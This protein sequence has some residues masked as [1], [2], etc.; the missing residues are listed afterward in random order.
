MNFYGNPMSSIFKIRSWLLLV[1]YQ[2]EFTCC[3]TSSFESSNVAYNI[4]CIS[5]FSSTLPKEHLVKNSCFHHKGCNH[6]TTWGHYDTCKP[7]SHTQT[8]IPT[9]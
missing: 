9:V 3:Y 4:D 6:F 1:E 7:G 8:L 5:L 2:T